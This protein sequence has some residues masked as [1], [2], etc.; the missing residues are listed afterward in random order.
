MTMVTDLLAVL[1]ENFS[2]LVVA[3]MEILAAVLLLSTVPQM[4]QNKTVCAA[5]NG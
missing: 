5:Q 3:C 4:G 2:L 1:G